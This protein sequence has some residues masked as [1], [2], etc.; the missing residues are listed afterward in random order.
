[1]Q[2]KEIVDYI[3]K[4]FELKN[5]GYYK[6]AIE[7]LYKALAI[8]SDNIEILAQLA[9]LYSLM[10]NSKR[11]LYY[12]EK[13][14]EINEN[15][16]DSLC[17]LK[18]I[19]L[20][21]QEF[22]SAKKIADKICKLE[23]NSKNISEKI[24]I[25]NQLK[26]FDEIREIEN[27]G[28]DLTDDILYELA[29]AY[30]NDNNPDKSIYLLNL[31]YQRN[32]KNINVLNLLAKI[33]YELGNFDNSKQM[34][35]EL[36]KVTPT[37]EVLN[38]LGLFSLNEQNY[39]KAINY[40]K[41]ANDLEKN[42]AEYSY[43]LAS[44]Y[45]MEGWLDEALKYFTQAIGL[46]PNN[47]DYHYSL[48]YLYYQ[49]KN[50]QKANI[51]LNFINERDKNHE[52]SKV[53]KALI[54][55]ENGDL[56]NAKLNLEKLAETNP[57]DD[58]ISSS[59]TKIYKELSMPDMAKVSA[60][61]ALRI[62][63]NSLN[64]LNELAELFIEEKCYE[65]AENLLE[66]MI[67]ING[68]YLHAYILKAKIGLAKKDF[69]LVF[70]MAQQI[71]DL[72]PNNP[73]GYYYNAIALFEQGDV[74]FAIESLKKSISLDLY[75]DALYIKMSEFYQE[76]G[77]FKNAFQWAN[78]ACDVNPQS[79]VNNW[80]CAK[81]ASALHDEKK[82]LKYYSQAYRLSQHDKDLVEDYTTYLSSVGKQ[83]QANLILDN[84]KKNNLIN[85]NLSLK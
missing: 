49:R 10:D 8:D 34:F 75:N 50:Y 36:E 2:D 22:L 3:K 52:F 19:Y 25:H 46:D 68:K 54:M 5:Q 59:L 74:N 35:M 20:A 7:M 42:S 55:S 27:S 13:V 78:E 40:F 65:E 48:A 31:A 83:K 30:K 85:K 12:I 37:A 63:P 6:P 56:L 84:A 61:K 71:I 23:P 21:Q 28:I 24:R 47:I 82:T 80:L 26:E 57:D 66:K 53:L 77:D 51:E 62:K 64:Y 60:Q 14:L 69:V 38:Y 17:L 81:L 72:D 33:Y 73:E 70:D 1:M 4:S 11:A 67:K 44:A 15:H 76:L 39:T 16:L 45:F 58:F 41:K 29:L 43:N 18:E 79:Y 32:N 9:H